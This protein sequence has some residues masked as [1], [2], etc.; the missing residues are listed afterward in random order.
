MRLRPV[1]RALSAWLLLGLAVTAV[2]RV[3]AAEGPATPRIEDFGWLAGRWESERNGRRVSEQWMGP[4]GGTML[5]M[6]RTVQDGRTREWEFLVLA[7]DAEGGVT[8][9]AAPSGQAR[10]TFKLATWTRD[11]FVVENPTHDFPQ[12]IGYALQPDG[13]L[14]AWIE[15]ERGGKTRRIEFAYRRMP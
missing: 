13:S 4:A 1:M 2:W 6:S 11:S 9:T 12:R 5:A 15:G 3:R 14:R 8:L 10:T 7:V